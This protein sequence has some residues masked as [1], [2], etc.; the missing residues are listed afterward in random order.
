MSTQHAN[1]PK[2][3]NEWPK[4]DEPRVADIDVEEAAKVTG[5]GVVFSGDEEPAPHSPPRL[6][7]Q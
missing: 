5:G 7:G 3:S 2:T 1:E 6:A 4:S